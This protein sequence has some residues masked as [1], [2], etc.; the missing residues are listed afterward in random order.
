MEMKTI[1]GGVC[2]A[3]G[4]LANGVHCGIRKN[5]SKRDLSLIYSETP[6]SAAAAASS[7]DP[8]S[9]SKDKAFFMVHPPIWIVD[10]CNYG[11]KI[12]PEARIVKPGGL[13]PRDASI[14]AKWQSKKAKKTREVISRVV[15]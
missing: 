1:A 8:P 5:R 12:M 7:S 11:N 4:F 14:R 15:G 6:A 9:A 3:K 13:A 10:K 2:A